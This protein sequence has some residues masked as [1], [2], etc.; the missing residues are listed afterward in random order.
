MFSPYHRF[1]NCRRLERT[2]SRIN[3]IVP[4]NSVVIANYKLYHWALIHKLKSAK[5]YIESL[6]STLSTTSPQDVISS[7]SPFSFNVNRDIDGFF[8]SNGSALD[9]L[10][11]EVM[12]YFNIPFPPNVYYRTA[13]QELSISRPGHSILSKLVDPSWKEEFSNYRNA[14][15]HELL[16]GDR[17]SIQVRNDGSENKTQIVYPLPD[18]PRVD[19]TLRTYRRNENVLVYCS[20]T[21]RRTLSLIS[22]VYGEINNLATTSNSIPV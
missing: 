2:V 16:I 14:L 1:E 6:D 3:S 10:A 18:D 13:R 21:F 15:T 5:Y 4:I 7:S 9:I 17:C 8:Y 20:N 11:R 22:K 19:A 12:T